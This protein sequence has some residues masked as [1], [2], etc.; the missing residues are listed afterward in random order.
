MKLE[1]RRIT[2]MA[3]HGFGKHPRVSTIKN[4]RDSDSFTF[5]TINT[6]EVRKVSAY[7]KN[8]KVNG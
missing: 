1:I 3:Q 7:L 4:V 8:I 6:V 5:K 2:D